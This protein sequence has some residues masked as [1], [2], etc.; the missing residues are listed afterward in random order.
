MVIY[1]SCETVIIALLSPVHSALS[2]AGWRTRRAQTSSAQRRRRRKRKTSEMTSQR[3]NSKM[4]A[5]AAATHTTCCW[6][7]PSWVRFK[8]CIKYQVYVTCR[9]KRLLYEVFLMWFHEAGMFFLSAVL[10]AMYLLGL[11]LGTLNLQDNHRLIDVKYEIVT[12]TILKIDIKWQNIIPSLRRKTKKQ[13][14]NTK[15]SERRM[16]QNHRTVHYDLRICG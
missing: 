7:S 2:Q 10:T 6:A 16:P 9:L 14:V 13:C 5:T 8:S 3:C 1:S 4:R 15:V 11:K 12:Y